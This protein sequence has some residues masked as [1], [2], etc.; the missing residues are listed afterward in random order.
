MAA[1]L[2]DAIECLQKNLAAPGRR[3]RRLFREAE[4]WIGSEDAVWV[5]SFRNICDVLGV[6]A[7]ALREQ[8]E[9]WKRHQS[10]LGMVRRAMHGVPSMN[11]WPSG[12]GTSRARSGS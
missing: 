10:Q 12:D 3:R 8:A 9:I 5:F 2:T 1:I 4:E 7:Q 11:T 6:D